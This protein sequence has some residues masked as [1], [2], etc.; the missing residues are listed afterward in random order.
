MQPE[1]VLQHQAAVLQSIRTRS[2]LKSAHRAHNLKQRMTKQSD[3]DQAALTAVQAQCK[4]AEN[5]LQSTQEELQIARRE[6][7]RL[8]LMSHTKDVTTS[9]IRA[10]WQ[11]EQGSLE[12]KHAQ[13]LY[14]AQRL[15]LCKLVL[16]HSKQLWV[17][18]TAAHIDF[19][20]LLVVSALGKRSRL[21][22]TTCGHSMCACEELDRQTQQEYMHNSSIAKGIH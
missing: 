6:N 18:T 14:I 12:L 2:S 8:K 16:L 21:A 17:D 15:R 11:G 7:E 19:K 13:E 3:Y 10:S 4:A 22:L 1:M 5:A 20:T 9:Q